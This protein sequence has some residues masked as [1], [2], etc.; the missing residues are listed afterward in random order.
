M[1]KKSQWTPLESLD[2]QIL[3][4]FLETLLWVLCYT[5]L[6]TQMYPHDASS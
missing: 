3:E 2:R 4:Q 1:N 6:K 5:L